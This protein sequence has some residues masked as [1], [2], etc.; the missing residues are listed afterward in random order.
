M[1]RISSSFLGNFTFVLGALIIASVGVVLYKATAD[2]REASELARHAQA[3][4]TTLDEI[5]EQSL[6]AA[7]D[8]RGFLLTGNEAFIAG[9]TRDE[10]RI[11]IATAQLALLFAGDE[12]HLQQVGKL[13]DLV[14]S[15]EE[16]YRES[17][18]LRRSAAAP[19]SRWRPRGC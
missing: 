9:R 5:T 16:R 10:G 8:Q 11:N 19:V 3:I 14:R 6:R 17:E 4:V 12:R 1:K 7:S 18:A 15:R 2:A 13:V